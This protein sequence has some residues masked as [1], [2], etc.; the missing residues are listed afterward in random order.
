MTARERAERVAENPLVK[1][2][3]QVVTAILIAALIG[4]FTWVREIEEGLTITSGQ[5][6][7]L[8]QRAA[9][10]ERASAANADA[11]RTLTNRALQSDTATA[12]LEERM[13]AIFETL[14]RIE[15]RMQE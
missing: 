4:M 2:A 1:L 15:Q 8:E 13:A 7:L 10:A 3:M 12:R 14:R 6:A 5:V 9:T 11:I